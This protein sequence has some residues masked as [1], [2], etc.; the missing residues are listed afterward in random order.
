MNSTTTHDLIDPAIKRLLD[1]HPD[2]SYEGWSKKGIYPPAA[3]AQSVSFPEDRAELYSL[4]V[5]QQIMTAIAYC[6]CVTLHP[7]VNSYSIKHAM[8]QWVRTNGKSS[9]ISNGCA[10]A[11]AMVYGYKVVRIRN[12]LNCY[13]QDSR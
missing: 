1:A 12:S 3:Y 13:L 6:Q 2:L 4:E 9:Y 8:E 11:G 5:Q 10:I 7:K